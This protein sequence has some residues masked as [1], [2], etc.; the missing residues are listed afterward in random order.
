MLG[1]KINYGP[2]ESQATSLTLCTF[3]TAHSRTYH[4]YGDG[5]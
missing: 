1:C 4:G 2:D 5:F 3:M